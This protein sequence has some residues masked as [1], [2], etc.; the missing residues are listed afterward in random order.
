MKFTAEMM[1]C[2]DATFLDTTIYKGQRF[3]K[4]SVLYVRTHFKATET[5]PIH[6]L[7]NVSPIVSKERLCKRRSFRSP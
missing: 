1:S 4:E 3:N 6:I 2:T 5:F 7:Y